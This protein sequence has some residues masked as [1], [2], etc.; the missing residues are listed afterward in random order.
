MK[1]SNPGGMIQKAA[2][3]QRTPENQLI[4]LIETMKPGI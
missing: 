3:E 1:T 2:Q 4:S